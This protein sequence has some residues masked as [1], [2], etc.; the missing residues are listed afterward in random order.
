MMS[1]T[2][3]SPAIGIVTNRGRGDVAQASFEVLAGLYATQ[4]RLMTEVEV[5]GRRRVRA[6]RQRDAFGAIG[7][8]V[9]AV[10]AQIDARRSDLLAQLRAN[11]ALAA[12][13]C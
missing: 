8:V 6:V 13:S 11:R 1:Q 10:I 5:L 3:N 9:D 12:W 7:L 4:T 2:K